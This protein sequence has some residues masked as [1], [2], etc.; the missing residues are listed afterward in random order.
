MRK[1]G[2]Y[3]PYS[4]LQIFSWLL[5]AVLIVFF[6]TFSIPALPDTGKIISLIV[7][8]LNSILVVAIAF[9]CTAIDPIDRALVLYSSQDSFTSKFCTICQAAVHENSKH[10][11]ECNKC[12]ELFDHHCKLLNNCIGQANYK[13]FIGLVLSL[14]AISI[15]FIIV[16]LYILAQISEGKAELDRLRQRF[17]LDS[18]GVEV[19]KGIFSFALVL[20]LVVFVFNSYLIGLHAWLRS[21]NLTTYQYILILRKRKADV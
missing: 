14:E 12:V 2:F 15:I 19:F 18:E 11:G 13:Y 10:C 5:I 9:R 1:N 4:K 16:D 20:G 8:T 6:Y 21:N 7:F 17:G 3:P